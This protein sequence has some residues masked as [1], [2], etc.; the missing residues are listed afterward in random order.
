MG[1]TRAACVCVELQPSLCIMA[2]PPGCS[3]PCSCCTEQ[4]TESGVASSYSSLIAQGRRL[5]VQLAGMLSALLHHSV[6]Q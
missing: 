6:L 2:T 1:L 5:Q 4:L 3:L